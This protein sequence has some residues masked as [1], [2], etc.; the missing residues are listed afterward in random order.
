MN[1]QAFEKFHSQ[2]RQSY[3][4]HESRNFYTYNDDYN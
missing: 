2:L 4:E 3:I 1:P